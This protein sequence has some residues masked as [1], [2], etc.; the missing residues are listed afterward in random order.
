[1]MKFRDLVLA[2][3]GASCMLFSIQSHAAARGLR[4]DNP[5]QPCGTPG[6][7]SV[8]T[9]PYV[10][11]DGNDAQNSQT[12]PPFFNPGTVVTP[13]AI[14]CEPDGTLWSIW[15][16]PAVNG[17]SGLL[18]T[19]N[20]PNPASNP[21]A[22]TGLP[23]IPDLTA[24]D[25][26]TTS[27][28]GGPVAVMYEWINPNDSN[29]DTPDAEV[30]VWTLPVNTDGVY[31]A[32]SSGGFDVELDN[33]CS[34][35]A[36]DNLTGGQT[37]VPAGATASFTWN[38]NVY[39]YVGDSNGSCSTA[40]QGSPPGNPGF[41]GDD[42]LLNN[43][44]VLIGYVN[45]ANVSVFPSPA[46]APGWAATF[47]TT[48]T[49]VVSPNPALSN[50][51]ASLKA[52]V[53]GQP[54]SP[55][56]TGSVKF[57]NGAT[58]LGT[59]SLNAGVATYAASLPVGQYSLT[60][61]YQGTGVPVSSQV[62]AMDYFGSSTSSAQ[63]LTVSAPPATVSIS[64]SPA[65]ITLGQSATLTWKAAN[66]TACTASGA[67]SGAQSTTG[68]LTA[69]PSAVGKVT[70][71]LACTG[72][73]GNASGMATLTVNLPPPTVAL[74]VSPTSI[75]VGQS[76]TLTWSSTNATSCTAGGAW[77]GSQ[78][79]GGTLSET[80]SAAGTLSYTLSCTGT[81]GSSSKT[82]ALTV[83]AAAVSH[84]GGGAVVIWDLVALGLIGAGRCYRQHGRARVRRGRL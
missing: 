61:A 64:M 50:S 76:A 68:T 69:T 15:N 81:G 43:N 1:V 9:D 37:P 2:L 31:P 57:Y 54:G 77:S 34:P 19:Q 51:V 36:Y 79:T 6:F 21:D 23:T 56:P 35:N 38:G 59:A 30:I 42:L 29:I 16:S 40:V 71:T 48:T 7:G 63:P 52:T 55:V 62:G 46:T 65:T 53:A 80:P 32:L 20:S 4:A 5:G 45:S 72:A 82:A 18:A 41:N 67:W 73:G 49:M 47:I 44:G 17:Q 14:F 58:L 60:A 83:S 10:P 3:I 84:G 39:N 25:M 11:T 33:W 24:I 8:S 22:T 74:A 13:P 70:Y 78:A 27:P 12:S 28:S 75:T 66:A 26:T